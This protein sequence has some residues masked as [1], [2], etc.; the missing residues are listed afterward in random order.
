M[1]VLVLLSIG[2]L[3]GTLAEYWVHRGMHK[4]FPRFHQAHHDNPTDR[5]IGGSWLV[6]GIALAVI[7][8]FFAF[9]LSWLIGVGFLIWYAVY[10]ALHYYSH[11]VPS[12]ENSWIDFE[13]DNHIIHHN[14]PEFNF[15]VTVPI[16]DML[17]KTYR[18][19]E[20][21]NS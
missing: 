8:A 19:G 20:D 21:R 3:L 17:F 1:K 15:G 12:R 5:T 18:R 7:F 11:Q 2:F 6:H 9:L 4:F 16:W 10:A 13:Q 14:E